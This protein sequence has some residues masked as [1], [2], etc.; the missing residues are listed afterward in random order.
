M[1]LPLILT[2]ALV[3]TA[4]APMDGA[5]GGAIADRDRTPQSCFVPS[6]V[7]N[8][9]TGRNDALYLRTTRRD[10]F[11]VSAGGCDLD[12][13][14]GFVITPTAGVSDRLCVGDGARILPSH[15]TYLQGPCLA[16]II[17]SLTPAEVEA[18]PERDRP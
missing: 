16:R 14:Y 11:E 4:C 18:L 6:Q 15:P 8:F 17:R 2:A 5:P 13:S 1:R 10:V 12:A 7:V 3:L 9:R